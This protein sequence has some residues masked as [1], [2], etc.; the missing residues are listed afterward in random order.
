MSEDLLYVGDVWGL[1]DQRVQVDMPLFSSSY[2]FV[3]QHI[4][5]VDRCR[6][7]S[8]LQRLEKISLQAEEINKKVRFRKF[9][10]VP[11]RPETLSTQSTVRFTSGLTG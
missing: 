5:D 11:T 8:N 6:Q 3:L 4:G 2:A 7:I 1:E 10:C 9:S